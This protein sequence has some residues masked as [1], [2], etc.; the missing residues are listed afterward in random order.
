MQA[1]DEDLR[2]LEI[3][4]K[5]NRIDVGKGKDGKSSR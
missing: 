4:A 3:I 2:D 1:E 5:A